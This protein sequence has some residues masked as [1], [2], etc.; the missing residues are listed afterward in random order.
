[1]NFFAGICIKPQK[2]YPR[3]SFALLRADRVIPLR[4]S[5]LA[6][7]T[8]RW[9]HFLLQKAGQYSMIEL[10]IDIRAD[11]TAFTFDAIE[12]LK[13]LKQEGFSEAQA[14]SMVKMVRDVQETNLS[15]IATKTDIEKLDNKFDN[16][17]AELKAEIKN[18]ESRLEAKMAE[19][20]VK[21]IMW[22]FGG[23]IS[24][25]GLLTAILLKLH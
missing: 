10:N 25:G 15:F 24:M 18:T 9:G 13:R 6:F 14:E 5:T 21:I 2:R 22:M 20:N 3:P 7:A 4:F 11:M 19:G 12:H 23:F 16:V 8:Q 1:M 17:R